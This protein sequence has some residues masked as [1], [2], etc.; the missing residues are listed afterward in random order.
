LGISAHLA[1]GLLSKHMKKDKANQLWKDG[2]HNNYGMGW[3]L[4]TL[5]NARVEHNGW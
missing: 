1:T 4:M 2:E 5:P 3:R